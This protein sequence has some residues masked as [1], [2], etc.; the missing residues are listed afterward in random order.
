MR[1][2]NTPIRYFLYARKST[3]SEDRQ[4]ASIDSQIAE[5]KK[6]AKREG[7]S[8]VEILYES[9]SAKSPGRS[10][11]NKMIDRIYKGE[12]NGILCWKLDRL[13][14]NPIDG[15][16]INWMLQ[17]GVIQHIQAHDKSYYPTDNVL[18]MSVEF[19]MANQ[20]I[21]D[22]KENT[23]RGLLTRAESGWFPGYPALGYLN[24]PN[25]SKKE[26]IIKDP[27]R[28]IIMRKVVDLMLTGRYSRKKLH[29]IATDDWGL[30]TR[31]GNPVSLANFYTFFENVFYCGLYEYPKGSS[32]WIEGKHPKLMTRGEYDRIQFL[33]RENRLSRPK[34]YSFAYRGFIR[35]GEC[36][37]MITA[38]NKIKRQKN[39]N[40]HHYIYYRCTKKAHPD[41]SQ[42]C[43]RE[44]E[45]EKQIVS[46]LERIELPE[47]FHEWVIQT[48]KVEHAK[49]TEQNNKFLN[50]Q[51]KAYKNCIKKIGNLIDMR[52][53]GEI[54]LEEFKAKKSELTK[55][56][57]R[58][59]G[60]LSDSN[61]RT[62]KWIERAEAFF[63]LASNAKKKFETGTLEERKKIVQALGSNLLLKDRKLDVVK[64][65]PL[66][67]AEE[68]VRFSKEFQREFEP[69]KK[70]FTKQ[71][72]KEFFDKNPVWYRWLENVRTCFQGINHSSY[73]EFRLCK[74]S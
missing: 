18:M 21:L 32:N 66:V 20:F 73:G 4:I 42:K 6:I 19:G 55:E 46:I 3:E 53:N 64:T 10:I 5:L 74:S 38:E 65:K 9:K 17:Q 61:D 67:V 25:R 22:L 12:A 58:L 50:T 11:F 40:V 47:N 56:K 33:I 52:T 49:E 26:K 28:F 36:G 45:L 15:G 1:N 60:L 63:Y 24:N 54:T 30:T 13:A 57:L 39:G 23:S 35:C 16:N 44:E 7:I 48:L 72:M 62:D 34:R 14:R 68:G 2:S 41:C 69:L 43:I 59:S 51:Q 31:K 27:D 8:I 29:M 37:A 71:D 70:R